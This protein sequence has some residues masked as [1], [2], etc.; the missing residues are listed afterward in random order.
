MKIAI[1]CGTCVAVAVF[2]VMVSMAT[3]ASDENDEQLEDR[4][5]RCI[6][7]ARIDRTHVLDDNN[8]LFYMRGKKVYINK[9]PHKCRGLRR[10]DSFMYKT[11]LSQL[12]DLDIITALD[13]IG[14][15]FSRGASC[16]LGTFY[17]IDKE[18]AKEL[19]GQKAPGSER[20][21]PAE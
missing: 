13:N 16:G 19:R 8:I 14:F 4:G 9:L 18:R 5:K 21:E 1:N 20:I 17:P 12:C 2:A 7:L 10:A 6:S 3:R 15:G 11:S